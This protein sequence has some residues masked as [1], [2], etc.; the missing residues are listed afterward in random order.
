MLGGVWYA[1]ASSGTISAEDK[2]TTKEKLHQLVDALPEPVLAEAEH[3]LQ[4][5]R[6][7]AVDPFLRALAAAPEDDEPETEEERAAIAEARAAI[8][9]GEVEPWEQVR[10]D[11]LQHH[12]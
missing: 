3:L 11:L 8:A 10:A 12:R 9:R 2:M 6:L 5:L 4:D 7:R 1:P